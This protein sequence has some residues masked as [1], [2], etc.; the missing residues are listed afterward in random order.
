MRSPRL[1]A[2]V[3]HSDTPDATA[4]HTPRPS[5]EGKRGVVIYVDPQMLRALKQLALDRDTS[6]Q[7][8]GHAALEALLR[9]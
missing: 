7:V 8:L 3:A 4:G 6:L 9:K 2:Q 1:R 5:R